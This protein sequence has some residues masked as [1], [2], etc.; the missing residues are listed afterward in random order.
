[1]P[2]TEL[3]EYTV[4]E[5]YGLP[6]GERAELIDGKVYYMAPPSRK[7]QHIV[8]ELFAKI[9]NYVRNSLGKYDIYMMPFGVFLGED[10]KNY[11][12]PDLCVIS[13]SNKLTDKGCAG[14]PDW[15]IEVVSSDSRKIDYT[16]KLFK[17]RTSGVREYWLVD[18][19][20]SRVMVYAF[21]KDEM[22]EY[23]FTEDIPVSIFTD[24]SIRMS[25]LEI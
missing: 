17:Y 19:E 20:K 4:N 11:V 25:E 18:S 1:M 13:D 24:F 3:K 23:S 16:T 5:I 21:Y 14:A 8:G 22:T 6:E 9:H 7:H 2:L 12:E 15:I 10:N